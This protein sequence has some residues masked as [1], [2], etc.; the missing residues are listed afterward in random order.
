LQL[1]EC[2]ARLVAGRDDRA[3]LGYVAAPAA[4]I[5]A[6]ALRGEDE[7]SFCVADAALSDNPAH[8][9]IH[10]AYRIPEADQIEY[11]HALMKVFNADAIKHRKSLKDSAVWDQLPVVLQGRT[12]PQQWASLA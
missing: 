8:T 1:A 7:Q 12:L 3:W 9:E 11:R 4:T 10:C 2:I 6:V 5:R